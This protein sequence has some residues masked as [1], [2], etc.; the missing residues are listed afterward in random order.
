MNLLSLMAAAGL[1]SIPPEDAGGAAPGDGAEAEADAVVARPFSLL[2]AALAGGPEG[3]APEGLV[4][5][6]GALPG[7][8]PEG[9]AEPGAEASDGRR[10]GAGSRHGLLVSLAGAPGEAAGGDGALMEAASPARDGSSAEGAAARVRGRHGPG[11][12]E[13]GEGDEAASQTARTSATE[14]VVLVPGASDAEALRVAAAGA[15]GRASGAGIAPAVAG[16]SEGSGA[17]DARVGP[18]GTLAGAGDPAEPTEP[19]ADTVSDD[20]RTPNRDPEL[21]APELQRRLRRVQERMQAEFGDRVRIVEG[22]RTRERQEFLFAKGRRTP[23]RVVTWTRE[24]LHT[25][26]RAV[27]V[28]VN[29]TWDDPAAYARLQ[30]VAGEEGLTTLGMRD[31]GHLELPEGEPDGRALAA[32]EG[33]DG[34]RSGGR[35]GRPAR[36]APVAPVARV[37]PVASPDGADAA[38]DA[39]RGLPRDLPRVPWPGSGGNRAAGAPATRSAP[40]AGEAAGATEEEGGDV[41]DVDESEGADRLLL[42][43]S[44]WG[45]G[46]RSPVRGERVERAGPARSLERVERVRELVD[47]ARARTPGRIHLDLADAD[48]NGTRLRL[49]L[50]G[51]TVHGTVSIPEAGLAERARARVD[52]LHR[53][54]RSRGID[55][56]GIRIHDGGADR[57][58]VGP[59]TGPDAVAAGAESERYAGSRGTG[60]DGDAAAR[61]GRDGRSGG[62]DAP[63]SGSRDRS[64]HFERENR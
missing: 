50:V 9:A 14:R 17:A 28:Q 39:T 54:L 3:R 53:A 59:R 38:A 5:G 30:R 2:L 42:G 22:Y 62:R 45:D 4:D 43:G 6:T 34:S 29:G 24:S 7:D 27:D 33:A 55:G 20:V 13:G 57:A 32:E 19:S 18:A 64:D 58:S 61:H 12:E 15:E 36:V 26:G 35:R 51:R 44:E 48:G 60:R 47:R 37:A 8:G 10:G 11:A 21:L 1:A 52:D 31:P 16:S 40:A 49:S 25:A 63:G 23:G 56:E 41:S 46:S